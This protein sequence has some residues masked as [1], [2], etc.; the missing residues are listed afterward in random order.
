MLFN[1]LYKPQFRMILFI[2]CFTFYSFHG[3]I[4]YSMILGKYHFNKKNY[5]TTIPHIEK[6]IKYYP[7]EIVKYH[8]MLSISYFNLRDYKK[9]QYY[10]DK[11]FAINPN[12]QNV[13]DI[14]IF[15]EKLDLYDI[16]NR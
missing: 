14:K 10:N 5:S 13:N 7:K 3:M 6:V 4:K 11:A 12:N 15:L 2:C 8:T 1:K 9:T 16:N